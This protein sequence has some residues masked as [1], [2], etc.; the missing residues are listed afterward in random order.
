MAD[1]STPNQEYIEKADELVAGLAPGGLLVTEQAM[2]FFEIAT[3]S[4]K[5]LSM[6]DVKT[7]QNPSYEVPK[8]GFTGEVLRPATEAEPV[9]ENERASSVKSKTTLTPKEYI[10]ECRT[11]YSAVEDNIIRGTF[12]NFLKQLVAKAVARDIE[13]AIIQG[14]T[15]GSGSAL[16]RSIDG[17]I[18]QATSHPIA[19]AGARLTKS[20]LTSM[21][22]AMPEQYEGAEPSWKYLTNKNAA[23]DYWDSF[24]DRQTVGGDDARVGAPVGSPR[25]GRYG[26]HGGTEIES[27]PLWPRN[28]T[29]T[30]S[31]LNH[32]SV[33]LCDPKN[34]CVCFRR[35][36]QIETERDIKRREYVIVATVRFDA[37]FI[38]E[39]AVVQAS[40]ILA[41]P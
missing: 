33:L 4:S 24:S 11:T 32:T 25:S 40:D 2:E 38:H 28:L 19:G 29:G 39:D 18:K 10:A 22:R 36:V 7:T 35:D 17:L 23:I 5:L 9:G 3:L 12:P 8:I 37:K 20:I 16:L 31:T 15:A 21:M 27:I 30:G 26:F 6:C 41:S 1:G 14:D 34:I 13:K